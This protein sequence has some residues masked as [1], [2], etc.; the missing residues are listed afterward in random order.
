MTGNSPHFPWD[1][2]PSVEVCRFP[3][4]TEWP[5][6]WTA[7]YSAFSTMDLSTT[8]ILS[9]L[10]SF[11]C[12]SFPFP[13]HLHTDPGWHLLCHLEPKRCMYLSSYKEYDCSQN[14]SQLLA[15][16]IKKRD[17]GNKIWINSSLCFSNRNQNNI[18][19]CEC[20]PSLSLF[21]WR[22]LDTSYK[23]T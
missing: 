13:W 20:I 10:N 23:Y 17:Y 18:K 9:Y 3:Q 16:W 5:S 21:Y 6:L 22:L 12:I 7:V 2:Q 1:L 4:Q 11:L 8:K 14:F 19:L 15:I